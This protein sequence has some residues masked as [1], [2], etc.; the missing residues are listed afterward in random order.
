MLNEQSEVVGTWG[1]RPAE[2]QEFYDAWRN[3]PD[4]LPYREFQIE[5]QKWYLKDKGISAFKEISE[6]LKKL[7]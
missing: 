6:I 4:K 1:P 5:P 7:V 3:M 2:A